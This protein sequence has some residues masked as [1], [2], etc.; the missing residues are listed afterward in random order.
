MGPSPRAPR[1]WGDAI[2]V[3]PPQGFYFDNK[4]KND[5]AI[6]D[7][8]K[9]RSVMTAKD[10]TP[11]RRQRQSKE[12]EAEVPKYLRGPAPIQVRMRIAWFWLT[13][14]GVCGAGWSAGEARSDACGRHSIEQVGEGYPL[15]IAVDV[16]RI[17]PA[18]LGLARW[19]QEFAETSALWPPVPSWGSTDG[20]RTDLL[21]KLDVVIHYLRA[22]EFPRWDVFNPSGWDKRPNPTPQ[23]PPRR[24][25]VP[26]P[27]GEVK[28]GPPDEY[29]SCWPA[30]ID[31]WNPA[32]PTKRRRK[33]N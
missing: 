32:W 30:E 22:T 20:R 18:L 17:R 27:R 5:A 10:P 29:P 1:D 24:L 13:D 3:S 9:E 19:I 25:F 16:D 33:K 26:R 12:K 7:I 14:V 8:F 23:M 21:P 31:I 11:R 6:P 15:A 2:R 28:V 4:R